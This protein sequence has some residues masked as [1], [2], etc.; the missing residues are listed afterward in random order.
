MPSGA[1]LSVSPLSPRQREELKLSEN[2]GV[3]VDSVEENSPAAAANKLQESDCILALGG[4]S[5]GDVETFVRLI[6][7]ATPNQPLEIHLLRDGKPVAVKLSPARRQIQFA[8]CAASP[9]AGSH[10]HRNYVIAGASRE[11]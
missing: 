4:Q 2:Q 1:P 11:C 3:I 10:V 5:V 6:G 9:N 7:A 8:I